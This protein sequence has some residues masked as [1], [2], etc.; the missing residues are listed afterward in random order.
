VKRVAASSGQSVAEQEARRAM[1]IFRFCGDM[2]HLTSIM[3]ASGPMPPVEPRLKPLCA[4]FIHYMDRNKGKDACKGTKLVRC[5]SFSG[6]IPYHLEQEEPDNA[7][8]IPSN[9]SSGSSAETPET[10][11]GEEGDPAAQAWPDTDDEWDSES[12]TSAPAVALV[13]MYVPQVEEKVIEGL[14][15]AVTEAAVGAPSGR[16]SIFNYIG[17]PP[18]INSFVWQLCRNCFCD[19]MTFVFAFA[20]LCRIAETNPGKVDVSKQTIHRLLLAALTVAARHRQFYTNDNSIYAQAGN[21]ST[22]DL[23]QLE[24]CFMELLKWN[25]DVPP[26]DVQ[27]DLS[28]PGQSCRMTRVRGF[29]MKSS[30]LSWVS[31]ASHMAVKCLCLFE[32]SGLFQYLGD[33]V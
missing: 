13:A 8:S 6:Y 18:D 32:L 12:S 2:L 11:I 22:T 10:D 14:C 25:L 19:T 33:G 17:D 31:E 27:E 28:P 30:D 1:N 7:E 4:T 26:Q 29:S 9:C 21:V 5:H 3:P 15:R 20:Y 23:S 16:C 24:A